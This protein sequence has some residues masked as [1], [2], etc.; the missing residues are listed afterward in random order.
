MH[1]TAPESNLILTIRNH[2]KGIPYPGSGPRS[3]GSENYGCKI[4][5]GR[6][7]DVDLIPEVRDNASLRNAVKALNDC[8]T[9]FLTLGCEKSCNRANVGSG[10]WMKGYLELALNYAH[11]IANAQNYFKLFFDF[12]HWFWE[13]PKQTGVQYDF[14][15]EGAQFIEAGVQ[16]FSLALWISTLVLPTEEEAKNAWARALDTVVEFLG[17]IPDKPMLPDRLY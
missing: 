9:P 1:D 11:A 6:P 17:T 3:D 2:Y 12:N 5:K 14:Q 15:L 16:G 13:Q 8:A 7:G 4:I 10:Y